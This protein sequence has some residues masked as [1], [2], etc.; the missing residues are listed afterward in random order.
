MVK[1]SQKAPVVLC[2]RDLFASFI[3]P[4]RL[5]LSSCASGLLSFLHIAYIPDDQEPISRR[6]WLG[7]KELKSKS[8]I[9]VFV[10]AAD[11]A[12]GNPHV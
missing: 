3:G 2:H 10:A 1:R 5:W 8:C 7:M 9:T 11:D 4:G 6:V 12:A